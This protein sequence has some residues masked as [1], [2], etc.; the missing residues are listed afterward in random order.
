MSAEH[1]VGDLASVNDRNANVRILDIREDGTVVVLPD[2]LPER[3]A[4]ETVVAALRAPKAWRGKDRTP[5]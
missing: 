5:A 4:T 1:R 2:G 3:Y